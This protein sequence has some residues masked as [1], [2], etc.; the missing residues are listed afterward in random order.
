M[1]FWIIIGI[2]SAVVIVAW[3]VIATKVSKE[4]TGT[5]DID[6]PWNFGH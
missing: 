3:V 5:D 2:V 4:A 6:D 1:A